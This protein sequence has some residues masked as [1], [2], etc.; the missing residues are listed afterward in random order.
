MRTKLFAVLLLM[1]VITTICVHAQ[2]GA[3]S[4]EKKTVKKYQAKAPPTQSFGAE[5]FKPSGKTVIRWMGM[6][7][8]FV[9]SR[10]TVFMV[11]PLLEGFDMKVMIDFPIAPKD[12]PRLDAIFVTHSDNDHYSIPT[13]KDLSAVTKAYH[14]TVYV[15][16]LMKNQGL[17]S[18]GHNIG[19]LFTIGTVSIKLTPVDHDW[20]NSFKGASTRHFKKEDACG[21]W[22]ETPDGSIWAT[23]DSRL[24]PEHLQMK[25]PDAIF[26]DFSDSEFHFG[27]AGAVKLANAYP[28][29]PLLLSH[30]GSVD[31]PDFT[32]FNGDPA[33]LAKLVVNPDRIKVLAPGEP[34]ILKR[35]KK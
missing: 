31:A 5:A 27:L 26:F 15:D 16:S 33:K 22:I 28:D 9:N 6:G 8:W 21:F 29:T 24:M 2:T 10:G 30:W 20:Q 35:L 25:T 18:S 7:G 23:G 4:T 14:S 34:Y 13:C 3:D 19:D 11:D 17:P 1:P 32:P 12:I